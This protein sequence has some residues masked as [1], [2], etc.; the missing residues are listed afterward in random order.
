ME[1][2][3]GCWDAFFL[4]LGRAHKLH[5]IW[6]RLTAAGGLHKGDLIPVRKDN[7]FKEEIHCNHHH[8]P[9]PL[10]FAVMCCLCVPVSGIVRQAAVLRHFLFFTRTECG[11]LG[12]KSLRLSVNR[13][14]RLL[15]HFSKSLN[16]R[17]CQP[18][19]EPRWM[20]HPRPAS[21]CSSSL[22]HALIKTR[23]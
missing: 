2:T 7:F 18:T 3:Q 17:P 1:R 20:R 12:I 4:F 10:L 13:L 8:Q 22:V 15:L 19:N 9:S 5:S 11:L 23:P 16:A 14:Y 21:N 6:K